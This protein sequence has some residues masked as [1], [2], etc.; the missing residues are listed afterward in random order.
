VRGAFGWGSAVILPAV[1]RAA[2]RRRKRLIVPA[3]SRAHLAVDRPRQLLQTSPASSRNR[4]SMAVPAPADAVKTTA[5]VRTTDAVQAADALKTTEPVQPPADDAPNAREHGQLLS[6]AFDVDFYRAIYTDVPAEMVLLEHYRV[7]GW[8]EGRDPAPWF[9]AS[10]YAA[11]NPDVAERAFDPFFHYLTQ[12]R[13]EGREVAPSRHAAAYLGQVDW[14]PEAWAAT[15]LRGFPAP[16]TRHA[17]GAAAERAAP[18]VSPAEEHGIVATAFDPA[19]YLALNP[20]VAQSGMAPLDHFLATGWREGRDPSAQFSVRDYLDSYPD[21]AQAGMNPFTH[22]LLA[23]R[24]EGRQPRHDLGFRHGV[25]ARLRPVE[26][27]IA[28]AAGAGARLAVEP[29]E[30]LAE[31]LRPQALGDLH[32]TFSHDNFV[33]N[34]GGLQLCLQRESARF[35]ELGVD[36]LHLYPATP[37]PTV[38]DDGEPGALGVLLNRA[39]LGVFAPA[40]IAQVLRGA[41]AARR[42]SFAIHSLIGHVAEETADILGALGLSEGF[43]WTHDFASLC[44]GVHLLR[45]DVADCA[46]P[47]AASA[48]CSVCAYG[49]FRAR[50]TDAHRR[51]FERLS[52]TVAAP[53]Q[54]T[55]DF[56][57]THGDLPAAATLVAPLAT[58]RSRGLA[59]RAPEGRR[60]RLAYLGMPA[61]LKGWPV[62]RDLA[63]RFADDPRYEFLHLGGRADPAAPAAFHHAVGS[64]ERPQ[65]MLET[66]EALEADAALIWPLCRETF[67]FTAYEAAAAGAAVITGP[68]SG[69][70]AT[71][72]AEPGRGLVLADEAALAE[73]FASGAILA[74]GRNRRKAERFDLVYSGMT[75]DLV[76]G[77]TA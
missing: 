29:A 24:A 9:S 62:F 54:T 73:A 22:Y 48:G 63:Q 10:A 1:V 30:R 42:R 75:A 71:F 27:R 4:N 20:D 16:L 40:A 76:A 32:V 36:H 5:A 59:S 21:V 55:L 12:G 52:L 46:A 67:S 35:A 14:A 7:Q 74:L 18:A 72:A 66:L 34:G 17:R 60:F 77:I 39:K 33:E 37:W 25:I 70:V 23:G 45:N 2:A 47:D 65:A 50:H 57:R 31:R 43:F 44:A 11:A 56:W 6:L 68:D 8:R 41:P 69:N 38:R 49:P 26:D 19:F 15:A 28:E 64:S 58:L 13:Y 53:S 61:S 3:R 51:L